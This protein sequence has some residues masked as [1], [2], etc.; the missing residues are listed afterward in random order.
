[1]HGH[2][3]SR[4]RCEEH[5]A[6]PTTTSV[7]AAGNHRC[8][9]V[10]AGRWGNAAPCCADIGKQELPTGRWYARALAA[11]A[12]PWATVTGDQLTAVSASCT[13]GPIVP[14]TRYSTRR[15]ANYLSESESER[16]FI[17]E[18]YVNSFN[19]RLEIRRSCQMNF[20]KVLNLLQGV[21]SLEDLICAYY[22]WTESANTTLLWMEIILYVDHYNPQ[23]SVYGTRQYDGCPVAGSRNLEWPWS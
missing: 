12:V 14:F 2:R 10:G 21:T 17:V 23:F 16:R 13:V 18:S 8:L 9:P 15:T 11:N 1:M 4:V 19:N 7:D 3:W 6:W 22:E 20:C 5:R